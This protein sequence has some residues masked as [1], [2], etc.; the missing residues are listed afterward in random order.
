M[1]PD[2]NKQQ[3]SS[4]SGGSRS[5]K[6][7]MADDSANFCCICKKVVRR[8]Q[9][10]LPH[11]RPRV[12]DECI[13]KRKAMPIPEYEV[14]NKANS[15]WTEAEVDKIKEYQASNLFLPFVCPAGH[16]LYPTSNALI[17]LVCFGFKLSWTYSWVLD[18]SWRKEL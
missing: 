10:I 16:V 15:P 6:V 9:P 14:S 3:T 12:C 2:K 13:W 1:Y 18:G 5:R 7:E 11:M 17:C 8:A 4:G